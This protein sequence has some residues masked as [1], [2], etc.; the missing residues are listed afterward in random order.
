MI[1]RLSLTYSHGGLFTQPSPHIS[2]HCI[3]ERSKLRPWNRR[4]GDFE[5]ILQLHAQSW[6]QSLVKRPRSAS[7]F[8]PVSFNF[9]KWKVTDDASVRQFPSK[10]VSCLNLPFNCVLSRVH[11]SLLGCVILASF[12]F[13]NNKVRFTLPFCQKSVQQ[14]RQE[15]CIAPTSYACP[16]PREAEVSP[17]KQR[18]YYLCICLCSVLL[19]SSCVF[20]I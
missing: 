13:P 4:W 6:R 17:Q 15:L 5:Y 19:S 16:I 11:F 12:H 20:V 14:S 2:E 3:F 18:I 8:S 1:F 7:R 9:L 10:E